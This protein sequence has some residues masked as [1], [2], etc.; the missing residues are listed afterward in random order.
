MAKPRA[1]V[2]L[3]DWYA[4]AASRMILDLKDQA[5]PALVNGMKH[6]DVPFRQTSGGKHPMATKADRVLQPQANIGGPALP[7]SYYGFIMAHLE[8]IAGK[9]K[10]AQLL[11]DV[12]K[13][14]R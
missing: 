7:T 2:Y 14:N 10:A 6:P 4:A 11:E 8:Q 13:K 5:V 9:G 1:A 3:P 12:H